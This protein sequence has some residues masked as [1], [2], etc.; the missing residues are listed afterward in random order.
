MKRKYRRRLS[1]TPKQTS[2]SH[3]PLHTSPPPSLPHSHITLHHSDTV[4]D[5]SLE[6]VP[7]SQSTTSTK[8]P[9]TRK[10]TGV[11]NNLKGS[12]KSTKRK[13]SKSVGIKDEV[14][15]LG[16]SGNEGL[17]SKLKE[18]S[19][20]DVASE[21]DISDTLK[22]SA[23]RV[24]S[25]ST[26]LRNHEGSKR[27][28][29]SRGLTV[30]F[31]NVPSSMSVLSKGEQSSCEGLRKS[32]SGDVMSFM[33]EREKGEALINSLNS[34]RFGGLE[35]HR[36][37]LHSIKYYILQCGTSL[38]QPLLS[39]IKVSRIERCLAGA[40]EPHEGTSNGLRGA[41]ALLFQVLHKFIWNR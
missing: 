9:I 27:R 31:V 1:S 19:E 6:N 39:Q 2:S 21:L 26:S 23:S 28:K 12:R 16:Y 25:E 40:H 35:H 37:L 24:V 20:G 15:T 3:V 41:H 7:P 34:S 29:T 5:T 30:S 22:L 8:Q 4:A 32:D 36:M 17:N 14:I 11:K 10:K 38:T 33:E 13:S 18:R